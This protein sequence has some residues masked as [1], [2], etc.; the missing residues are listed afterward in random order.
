M[1]DKTNYTVVGTANRIGYSIN[2]YDYIY[3]L[4]GTLATPI[5]NMYMFRL[6]NQITEFNIIGYNLTNYNDVHSRT[7]FKEAMMMYPNTEVEVLIDGV[8]EK[9]TFKDNIDRI[10]K[11]L[12][13]AVKNN[14][15]QFDE[16]LKV[17][18]GKLFTHTAN[19]HFLE[20]IKTE[21]R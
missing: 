5:I 21:N 4:G 2:D 10:L 18:V 16:A 13:D 19:T 17:V 1:E 12:M 15:N 8:V 20:N 9:V 14:D 6:G 11:Q 7:I 3:L